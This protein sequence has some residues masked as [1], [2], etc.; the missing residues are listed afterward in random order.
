[1]TEVLLGQGYFQRFDPKLDA[2][3]QPYPP[4]G[5][6]LAAAC[7]RRAGHEVALFDAVLA[8]SPREWDDALDRTRPRVAVVYEDSFNY[9]SKMCLG[10]MR[11]AGFALLESARRRGLATLV[12]G[13]DASDHDE[14]YLARGADAVIRGEGEATLVEALSA[15]RDGGTLAGVAGLSLRGRTPAAV[16]APALPPPALLGQ[17]RG[18]ALR[19]AGCRTVWIGAE[20]GPPP[21]LD[22]M[23]KASRVDD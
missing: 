16:P 15:W 11:E 18:A 4:L 12:A 19:P 22:A 5:T 1:M 8:E 2:A 7:L 21:V 20:S 3:G 6:L 9:L 10:R 14:A 23:E 17:A 13:S